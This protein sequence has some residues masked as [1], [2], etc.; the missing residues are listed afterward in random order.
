MKLITALVAALALASGS[1]LAQEA[2]PQASCTTATL[3]GRYTTLATGSLGHL[4]GDKPEPLMLAGLMNFDGDGN[5][6]LIYTV[7][8]D[9]VIGNVTTASGTYT[10]AANCVGALVDVAGIN[11][12]IFVNA[13]GFTG[14]MTNGQGFEVAITGTAGG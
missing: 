11:A 5:V 4:K 3:K 7:A 1:A 10:L 6:T 12:S 9:G 14:I 8:I 13:K 2:S